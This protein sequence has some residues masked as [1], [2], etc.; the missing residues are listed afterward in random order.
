[1]FFLVPLQVH[2]SMTSH[3]GLPFPDGVAVLR[4]NYRRELLMQL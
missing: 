3:C 4:K 2:G 1:M